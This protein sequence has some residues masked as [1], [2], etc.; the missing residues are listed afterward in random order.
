MVEKVRLEVSHKETASPHNIHTAQRNT[1]FDAS[2]CYIE[3]DFAA[4]EYIWHIVIE[5]NSALI[6]DVWH[7]RCFIVCI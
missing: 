2:K 7:I 1:I 3:I 4:F 5:V 6:D